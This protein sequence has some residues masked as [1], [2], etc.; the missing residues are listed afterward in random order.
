MDEFGLSPEQYEAKCISE[1]NEAIV[2]RAQLAVT[3]YQEKKKTGRDLPFF[4][5]L[6]FFIKNVV[7]SPFVAALE[8]ESKFGGYIGYCASWLGVIGIVLCDVGLAVAASWWI[9]YLEL[10]WLVKILAIIGAFLGTLV[11]A[12]PVSVLCGAI[13]GGVWG[14]IIGI[15]ATPIGLPLYWRL[16]DKHYEKRIKLLQEETDEISRIR[17]QIT[18]EILPAAK[19]KARLY[20]LEFNSRVKSLVPKMKN[21]DFIDDM[22][23]EIVKRTSILRHIESQYSDTTIKKLDCGRSVYITKDGLCDR[24]PDS[25][26][27]N[28]FYSFKEKRIAGLPDLLHIYALAEV[29]K[30]RIKK[31]LEEKTTV[32]DMPKSSCGAKVKNCE[33]KD[34]FYHIVL[35]AVELAL[36]YKADNP[37][38]VPVKEW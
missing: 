34:V 17:I 20:R 3:E 28:H 33:C 5:R 15:V 30:N 32:Y 10:M 29:L 31:L 37:N 25:I 16:P 38:F 19:E 14:A 24:V 6:W 8:S 23:E 35:S 9:C 21:S 12:L 22:V 11:V 13:G 7:K 36:Y 1:A 26:Q 18:D 2:K 27:M 4:Q